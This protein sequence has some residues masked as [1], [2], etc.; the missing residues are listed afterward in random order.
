M[1]EAFATASKLWTEMQ[2]NALTS[3]QNSQKALTESL[4]EI[5]N[6][7][8]VG[9]VIAKTGLRP[10]AADPASVVQDEIA[11]VAEELQIGAKDAVD[12]IRQR[13]LN[14]KAP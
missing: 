8:V 5:A 4:M 1:I 6:G 2:L 14:R 3:Y 13:I 12:Y 9:S 11:A 10:Y 7:S